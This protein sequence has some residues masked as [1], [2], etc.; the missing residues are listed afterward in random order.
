MVCCTCKSKTA[1][2]LLLMG[3]FILMTSWLTGCQSFG[4]RDMGRL[5]PDYNRVAIPSEGASSH[6][7]KTNDMTVQYQCQRAGD[8]LKVWGS[9]DIRYDSIDELTFH[10]YFIDGRGEVIS[11]KNFF[12]YA[13]HSDFIELNFARRQFHRDFTIPA[14]AVAFAIGYDG[15]TFPEIGMPSITFMYYPFDE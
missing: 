6:T 13:D 3:I 12:S 11:I 10:L 8:Q 7:L 14:G 1:S 2:A 4:Q 9:G 15:S 5:V